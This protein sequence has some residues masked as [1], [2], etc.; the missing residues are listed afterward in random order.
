MLSF[1]HVAFAL[2]AGNHEVGML[3]KELNICSCSLGVRY[4][5]EINDGVISSE[6]VVEAK[7]EWI[8]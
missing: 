1:G 3:N 8:E 5:L 4:K 2:A 6:V 7:R